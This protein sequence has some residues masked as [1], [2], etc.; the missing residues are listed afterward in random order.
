MKPKIIW[1]R[2]F[3]IGAISFIG[4]VLNSCTADSEY[5]LRCDFVFQNET[6]HTIRYSRLTPLSDDAE[7]LFE[8]E[9]NSE[10]LLQLE[11]ESEKYPAAHNAG[12]GLLGDFNGGSVLVEFGDEKYIIDEDNEGANSI[13]NYQVQTL[14]ERYFKYTYRFTQEMFDQAMASE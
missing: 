6:T 13:K 7:L 4:Y 5:V 11:G 12:A 10:Y 2:F 1:M 8:I 3:L 9:P 14:S